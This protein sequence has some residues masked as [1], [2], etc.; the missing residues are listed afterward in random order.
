MRGGSM[1]PAVLPRLVATDLDGT[2]LR[3]DGSC[4][5]R[6]RAALAG[7]EDAGAQVVLVTA[8]PP[9]WLHDLAD[10]V[11]EHGIVL[12][13]NGAF[14]YD[15]RSRQILE[16]HCMAA[17][18]AERVARDLREGLPGIV[19]AVE[20]RIGFSREPG[21]LDEYTTPS[22]RTAASVEELLDPPPGKILARC[23]NLPGPAFHQRVEQVV[24][25]RGV[26]SYSGAS[27]LAEISAWGVT[28]AAALADWCAAQGIGA[29]DVFAFGDM[30]N[31]L[32]MLTWAG[33]S[34]GV[35]NAHSEVLAMVDHV[36]ASNEDDG[37]AQV[38]EAVLAR[39]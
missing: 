20:S 18:M 5:A 34:F 24:G 17:A 19:F 33:T 25:D 7:I 2:L 38:L 14:V 28:K 9:R 22:D 16:E 36:C 12:C 37:V 13:C 21:F 29:V 23:H 8:R 30:P 15:V 39:Q 6:T 10:V 11:G 32:P 1:R 4:S 26:V 27:G 31:D 3:N 35:E